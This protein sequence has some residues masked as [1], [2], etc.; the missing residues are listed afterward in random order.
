MPE[1]DIPP[2]ALLDFAVQSVEEGLK[3]SD[4]ECFCEADYAIAIVKR[5]LLKEQDDVKFM[6]VA[7]RGV[8]H[9]SFARIF[10]TEP[11]STRDQ[12]L[13][14]ALNDVVTARKQFE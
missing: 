8:F 10:E 9:R 2:A 7:I 5:L 11:P 13:K 12:S 1:Q 6:K 4:R 3:T 14:S